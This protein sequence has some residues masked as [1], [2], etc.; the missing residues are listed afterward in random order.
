[1]RLTQLEKILNSFILDR[2]LNEIS[3]FIISSFEFNSKNCNENSIFFALNG[4]RHGIEFF[5]NS[6]C[7]VCVTDFLPQEIKD[8]LNEDKKYILV[9]D[10]LEALQFLAKYIRGR[11]CCR[12]GITGSFGKTTTKEVIA[13][14]L[15]IFYPTAKNYKNY[16]NF[17]GLPI[18]LLNSYGKIGVFEVGINQPNEMEQLENILKP[19]IGILTA[20]GTSHSKFFANK[21]EIAKE[22]LKLFNESLVVFTNFETY[23][24]LLENSLL[25]E[26]IKLIEGE[27]LEE[28]YDF[29]GT[30]AVLEFNGNIL[31]F[32]TDTI[33]VNFA[34]KVLYALNVLR[35]LGFSNEI[36]IEKLNNQL[37]KIANDYFY[38]DLTNDSF[39]GRMQLLKVRNITIMADYYN[40]S[41]DTLKA[42]INIFKKLLKD[43]NVTDRNKIL[44]IIGDIEEISEEDLKKFEE[45]LNEL[46]KEYHI[47]TVGDKTFKFNIDCVKLT[48]WDIEMIEYI[49]NFEYIYI[50]GSR[51]WKLERIVDDLLSFEEFID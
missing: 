48:D 43:N 30:K 12:I 3:D 26:G 38:L 15:S 2:N 50:K 49:K 39:W 44:F 23:Q 37:E 9:R 42:G 4:K 29:T 32:A 8:K 19:D 5:N 41:I 7:K 46:S 14:L 35:L 16:N 25:N 11:F 45:L 33:I 31:K 24:F 20:I 34:V 6:K 1:M 18:S 22:K 40:S 28:H 27:I 10:T 51:K 13:K 47:L 36:I 17:L 21:L